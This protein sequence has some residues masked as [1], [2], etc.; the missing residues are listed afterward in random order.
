MIAGRLLTLVVAGMAWYVPAGLLG[1]F[2]VAVALL[3]LVFLDRASLRLSAWLAVVIAAAAFVIVALI[4]I[5]LAGAEPLQAA[6]QGGAAGARWAVSLACA[7]YIFSGRF[8][9][10]LLLLAHRPG[11]GPIVR[12]IACAVAIPFGWTGEAIRRQRDVSLFRNPP[13]E[14]F[15][16]PIFSPLVLLI[17][18]YLVLIASKQDSVAAC[19]R[20]KP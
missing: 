15:Y 7:G 6:R 14:S 4:E 19:L 12:G 3:A 2:A 5:W 8:A 13:R 11:R 1:A 17:T 20:L 9:A 16:V 18:D 10:D